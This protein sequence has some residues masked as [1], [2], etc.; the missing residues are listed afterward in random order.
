MLEV[1]IILVVIF[2]GIVGAAV[3]AASRL[4]SFDY[5]DDA[6]VQAQEDVTNVESW[7]S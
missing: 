1:M 2:F 6:P 5:L 4:D 7:Y 3:W